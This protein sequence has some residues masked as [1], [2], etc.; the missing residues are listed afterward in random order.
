MTVCQTL[1]T[2]LT[3]IMVKFVVPRA[4][5]VFYIAIRYDMMLFSVEHKK[6]KIRQYLLYT[7]M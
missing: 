7:K 6:M 1:F 4:V 5:P 2:I 3:H